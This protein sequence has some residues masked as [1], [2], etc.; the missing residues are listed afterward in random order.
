MLSVAA[1]LVTL[2]ATTAA[3]SLVLATNVLQRMTADIAQSVE[4]VRTIE[5][6]E[7]TL[8]LHVRADDPEEERE[9]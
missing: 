3:L 5:E 9:L 1:V 6:A 8:L 4:S 7:V 2:L